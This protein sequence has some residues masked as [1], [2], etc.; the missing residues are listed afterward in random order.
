MWTNQIYFPQ[1][2]IILD[3]ILTILF[4]ILASQHCPNRNL[5]LRFRAP[6]VFLLNSKDL[7]LSYE[8]LL[9]VVEFTDAQQHRQISQI[10]SRRRQSV[11]FNSSHTTMN[12]VH[13]LL[14]QKLDTERTHLDNTDWRILEGHFGF[15][16]E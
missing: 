11:Y 9:V 16:L 4:Y 7:S 8:N 1:W 2:K 3:S 12:K 14:L 5:A 13:A 6:I 15:G 10:C